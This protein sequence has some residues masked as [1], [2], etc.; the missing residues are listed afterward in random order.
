MYSHG[1]AIFAR[2]TFPCQDTPFAKVL[3]EAKIRVEE[4]YTILFSGELKEK[5]I[6]S[7]KNKKK[8][9][10]KTKK[11]NEFYFVNKFPISPYLITIAAGVLESKKFGDK[12][13]VWAEPSIIKSKK[14]KATFFDCSK[15]V[16]F[17]D[18]NIH[19]NEFGMMVFVIVPDDFPYGGMENPYNIQ[20]SKS[21]LTDDGSLRNVV[22]HE[23]AHF[24]SGNLVTN[25]NWEHFWLNEGITN[26][27]YRKCYQKMF[28]N[29]EFKKELRK[30]QRRLKAYFA[31]QKNMEENLKRIS[32]SVNNKANKKSILANDKNKFI[33][34]N[35]DKSHLSLWPK[36]TKTDPYNNF[37]LVPYEKGFSFLYYIEKKFGQKFIFGLLR[38]YFSTFKFKSATTRDFINLLK[39]KIAKEKG[40]KLK[41]KIYKEMN[42]KEWIHGTKNI[43]V[44]FDI[45]SEISKKIKNFVKKIKNLKMGR[46]KA[47]KAIMK[48]NTYFRN[49]ILLFITNARKNVASKDKKKFYRNVN[50]IINKFFSLEKKGQ[51]ETATKSR[52]IYM[53]VKFIRN[54]EKKKAF[55]L[56]TIFDFKFYK[57]TYL[58]RLLMILRNKCKVPKGELVNLVNK[59]KS[60]LNKLTYLRLMQSLNKR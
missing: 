14:L 38:E 37:S 49:L 33:V 43:P 36:I 31:K 54:K 22:A 7:S 32:K 30:S 41:E 3:I 8:N 20:V 48:Y 46:K 5:K 42:F 10:I 16:D 59:L 56:K 26:Y 4:P 24:W 35:V 47:F 55:I 52:L 28:G 6:I 15:F 25:K 34:N 60:R 23:I 27:L 19:K 58:K 45:E 17:F 11:I 21:I 53:K 1:P 57:A 9:N 2:T 39:G 40:E 13:I 51:L 44:T 29:P 50:Y 12:C 18:K